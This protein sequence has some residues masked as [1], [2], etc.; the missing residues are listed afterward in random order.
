MIYRGAGGE[1]SACSLVRCH[2]ARLLVCERRRWNWKK[3]KIKPIQKCKI[4]RKKKE[5]ARDAKKVIKKHHLREELWSRR[6]DI[7]LGKMLDLRYAARAILL[8]ERFARGT[9]SN[10]PK[11]S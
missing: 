8:R 5:R 6:N 11:E 3:R 4:W 1:R 2:S 9:G 10:A 7:E